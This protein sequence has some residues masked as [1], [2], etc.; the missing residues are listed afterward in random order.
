MAKIQDEIKYFL[1]DPKRPLAKFVLYLLS[2]FENDNLLSELDE[3]NPNFQVTE[4]V[5]NL[6]DST[7]SEPPLIKKPFDGFSAD[8]LCFIG[9]STVQHHRKTP[10][11]YKEVLDSLLKLN[12][13]K[14]DKATDKYTLTDSGR[15]ASKYLGPNIYRGIGSL[16]RPPTDLLTSLQSRT[17]QASALIG[18]RIKSGLEFSAVS[19]ENLNSKARR[20]IGKA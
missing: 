7:N 6:K 4:F 1:T 10:D 16:L 2:E 19:L 12:F 5:N 13:V 18:P 20:A 17:N 8:D 11:N 9:R 14:L 15:E 3:H